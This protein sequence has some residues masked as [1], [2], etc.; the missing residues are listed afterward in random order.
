MSYYKIVDKY[1]P[2]TLAVVSGR[3]AAHA[4]LRF[5]KLSKDYSEVVAVLAI[6]WKTYGKR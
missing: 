5:R 2:N 3:D 6:G 4:I 1:R